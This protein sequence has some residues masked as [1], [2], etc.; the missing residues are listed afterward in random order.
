MGSHAAAW[1]VPSAPGD[2]ADFCAPARAA[3]LFIA[4][5]VI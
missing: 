3:S 4:A 5:R 1:E 2:G